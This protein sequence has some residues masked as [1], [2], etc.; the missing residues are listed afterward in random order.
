MDLFDWEQF[1]NAENHDVLN[2]QS[3]SPGDG[4]LNIPSRAPQSTTDY[5]EPYA[6][7]QATTPDARP[8]DNRVQDGF[9][10]DDNFLE[11]LTYQVRVLPLM[12]CTYWIYLARLLFDIDWTQYLPSSR[13]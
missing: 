4:S 7:Q 8:R 10:A 13:E 3:F 1:N 5:S 12:K 2:L 6:T 11:T 9:I